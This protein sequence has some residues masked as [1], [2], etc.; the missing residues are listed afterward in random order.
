[1]EKLERQPDVDLP[2]TARSLLDRH[3]TAM[4]EQRVQEI[5]ASLPTPSPTLIQVRETS[6]PTSNI[7]IPL[8]FILWGGGNGAELI[9]GRT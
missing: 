6:Q 2:E 5:E 1:M 9:T 7:R 8:N 4:R 3:R